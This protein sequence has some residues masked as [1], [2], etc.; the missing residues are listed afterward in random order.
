MEQSKPPEA[1]PV[2]IVGKVSYHGTTPRSM[3]AAAAS[4][5]WRWFWW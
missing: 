4:V 3:A 1:D 2:G 5:Q